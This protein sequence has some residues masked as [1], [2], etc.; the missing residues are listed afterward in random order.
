MSHSLAE[1][2]MKWFTFVYAFSH[3][4]WTFAPTTKKETKQKLLWATLCEDNT[5]DSVGSYYHLSCVSTD[6]RPL[7]SSTSS[8]SSSTSTSSSMLYTIY[9]STHCIYIWVV[10]NKDDRTNQRERCMGIHMSMTYFLFSYKNES[11]CSNVQAQIHCH[12]HTRAGYRV[13][14]TLVNVA[15][16]TTNIDCFF[17]LFIGRLLCRENLRY[18][19]NITAVMRLPTHKWKENATKI[20][21]WWQ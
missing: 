18:S 14:N 8:L 12:T 5:C 21:R 7:F 2:N 1:G 16:Q 15:V 17:T 9:S 11:A 4:A 3:P 6:G 20:T 10:A 19:S 13:A